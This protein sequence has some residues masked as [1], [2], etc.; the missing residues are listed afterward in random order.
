MW[1]SKGKSTSRSAGLRISSS[2]ADFPAA[3]TDKLAVGKLA[4]SN[5]LRAW[6]KGLCFVGRDLLVFLRTTLA[7]RV[8]AGY[9][10]C[11]ADAKGFFVL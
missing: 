8:K 11:H 1:F 2:S 3:A 7:P 10:R 9:R 6:I 4:D 5:L